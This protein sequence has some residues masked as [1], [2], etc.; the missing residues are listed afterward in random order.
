MTRQY[1]AAVGVRGDCLYCPL[2][3][4]IDSYWNCLTNCYH[5]YMR[6][7]NRT[8]GEDLR[9]ADPEDVRRKL[10]NG[11]NNRSPKSTLAHALKLKKTLRLGNKTDP[12]QDAE[13]EHKVSRRIQEVLIELEWTYVIQSRH[14]EL[15]SRDE[16]LMDEAHRKGLLTVMPVITSGM[17]SDWEV[18]ERSRTTPIPRRLELIRGWINRGWTVGVQGEPFI[19]GYHTVEQ[20]RDA[21]RRIKAVGVGSYNTYN[22]HFNDHVAKQLASI[23]I[24]VRQIWEMNQDAK[25][26]PVLRSLCDVANREGI[27]LGC[28]DFVNVDPSWQEKANTCCG[29]HVPN[30]SKFN[31]H[32]WRRLRQR[33]LSDDAV[34]ERTW[35]GIGEYT[36]GS[37]VVRDQS[38]IFFTLSDSGKE[39]GFGL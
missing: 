22:L 32:H 6:R 18:L 4:C 3:L 35:E 36:E 34:L 26:R 12:Y 20:F 17:E 31:T 16:D 39:G 23:G 37:K 8:W 30:P 25:W 2:P 24:D 7:L 33:G 13:K 19:P 14:L 10:Q 1:G 28:P 29:I 5:C 9:P 38:D 27:R 15:L 21:I 11:L